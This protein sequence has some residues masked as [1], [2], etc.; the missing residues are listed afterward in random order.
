MPFFQGSQNKNKLQQY[1]TLCLLCC[2]G[3][4]CLH[5]IILSNHG[6]MD[7]PVNIL[8]PY[9]R[10]CGSITA[11]R[12]LH[13]LRKFTGGQKNKTFLV[14]CNFQHVGQIQRK[15]MTESR[16]QVTILT[17]CGQY[18]STAHGSHC[19]GVVIF[20]NSSTML[21]LVPQGWVPDLSRQA[22][23][24]SPQAQKQCL[25]LSYPC[26]RETKGSSQIQFHCL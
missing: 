18:Q 13:I 15:L 11:E 3:L 20:G 17:Q 9:G 2:S 7:S 26:T 1:C 23:L 19:T 25:A 24:S 5:V 21:Q 16:V 8:V 4:R 22:R 10:L 14:W 12:V 6:H